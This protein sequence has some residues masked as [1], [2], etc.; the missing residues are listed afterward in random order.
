MR[1]TD[2]EMPSDDLG[3]VDEAVHHGGGDVV[4]VAENLSDSDAAE[5]TITSA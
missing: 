1:P 4:I 3:L 2:L 5:K